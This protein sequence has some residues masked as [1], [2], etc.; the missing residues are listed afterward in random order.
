MDDAARYNIR[1]VER[2]TAVP[3][4]TLRSWERRYGFPRPARSATDR[5]LYSDADVR[6]IRWVRAQTERGLSIAQAVAW[7]QR[8]GVEG[9]SPLAA[10]RDPVASETLAHAIVDAAARYDERAVEAVLNDAFAHLGADAVLTRVITPALVEIGERWAHGEFSVAVEHFATNLVRRRLL[11][12]LAAQPAITPR[13]TAALACLPGEQ[14]EIGLLMLALFLRWAGARILY[15]GP[16]M[17]VADLVRL[18]AGREIDA[19]CLSGGQHADWDALDELAAH[20]PVAG[21][22]LRIYVGGGGADRPLPPHV[23]VLGGD[24]GAAAERIVE[25]CDPP[26]VTGL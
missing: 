14:H 20:L 16:D 1:A 2:L 9:L 15:L 7:A 8:G 4:P 12:L 18:G 3:A 26:R 5:R 19:L 23:T 13:L 22:A 17:P 24:L 21:A 6:A 25:E 11:A 10:S